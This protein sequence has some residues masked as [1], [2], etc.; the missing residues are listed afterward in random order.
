MKVACAKANVDYLLDGSAF[1]QICTT[2]VMS[3][4]I[5]S[6]AQANVIIL[7]SLHLS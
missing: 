5:I 4:R 6:R 1:N 2:T 3:D 7:L